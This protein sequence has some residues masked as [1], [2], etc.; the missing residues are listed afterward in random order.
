MAFAQSFRELFTEMKPKHFQSLRKVLSDIDKSN[1]G[2]IMFSELKSGMI[3][4]IQINKDLIQANLKVDTIFSD[5]LS[6]VNDNG[7]V[8]RDDLINVATNDYIIDREENLYA[9][10]RE[11]DKDND[12]LISTKKL[13]VPFAQSQTYGR[14]KDIEKII[15]ESKLA[16]NGKIDYELFLNKLRATDDNKP[17]WFHLALNADNY[18][19]DE[20]ENGQKNNLEQSGY[21][22]ILI[23]DVFL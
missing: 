21:V 15:E 20:K 14:V 22:S 18:N 9:T 3:E 16:A 6:Q 2:K 7:A 13:K 8:I 17:K 11:L 10:F 19:D 1:T 12:R 5:H 4:F 23:V